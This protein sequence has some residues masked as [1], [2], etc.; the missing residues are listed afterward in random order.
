MFFCYTYRQVANQ[1][2][3]HNYPY[4]IMYWLM[5]QICLGKNIGC[6]PTSLGFQR[7][8]GFCKVSEALFCL[9]SFHIWHINYHDIFLKHNI[10]K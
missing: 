9:I 8:D 2:L 1:S 4:T 6:I 10:Y 5:D 7:R 3:G